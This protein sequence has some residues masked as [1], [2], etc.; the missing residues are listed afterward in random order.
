M[1][2]KPSWHQLSVL[3]YAGALTV[4]ELGN[5]TS[6]EI[7]NRSKQWFTTSYKEVDTLRKTIGK[8]TSELNRRKQHA[9]VAPTVR[10]LSN[11]RL[12]EKK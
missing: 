5:Q 6:R 4:D 10:Q 11:I 1:N 9:D 7:A 3:V 12:L 8:A 2:G